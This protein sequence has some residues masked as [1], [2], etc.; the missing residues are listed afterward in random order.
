M[1]NGGQLFWVK[2]PR[3]GSRNG[4]VV[5]SRGTLMV[6][7]LYFITKILNSVSVALQ[8]QV[9][10]SVSRLKMGSLLAVRCQGCYSAL[11][12]TAGT[13]EDP[14]PCQKLR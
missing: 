7:Y 11:S 5:P 2:R 12:S 4:Q 13:R 3:I 1:I 9:D 10:K 6:S 14:I 8:V